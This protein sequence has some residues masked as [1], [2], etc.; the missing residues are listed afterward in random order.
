MFLRVEVSRMGILEYGTVRI[1]RAKGPLRNFQRIER[2]EASH[3]EV[4]SAGYADAQY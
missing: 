1:L 2:A 3:T 4:C